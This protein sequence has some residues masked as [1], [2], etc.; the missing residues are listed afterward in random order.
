VP[1]ELS[2]ALLGQ[3]QSVAA[4]CDAGTPSCYISDATYCVE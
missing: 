3:Q 4:Q 2:T 1:V